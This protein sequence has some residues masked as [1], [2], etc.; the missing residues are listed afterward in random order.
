MMA[1]VASLAIALSPTACADCERDAEFPDIDSFP[2][3]NLADYAQIGTHPSTSVYRFTTPAGVQCVVGM[4]TEMGVQCWG[5]PVGAAPRSAITAST[6]AAAAY[7]EQAPNLHGDAKL[8]PAD[9]KLDAGNGVVC[10]VIA[11]DT[12]ACRAGPN[13]A[14]TPDGPVHH[15]VHGF[16]I[17]P[18]G[19]WTF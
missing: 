1:A 2:A 14:M 17:Q 19:N 5:A 11:D 4:I 15:G 12:L 7:S 16:V 9:S 6:L 18:S 13:G 8:L 10:A 3:V